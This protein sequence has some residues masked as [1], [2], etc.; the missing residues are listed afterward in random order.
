[1]PHVVLLGDSIFDNRAYVG[2]NPDVRQQTE[3][4]LFFAN[5]KVTLLAR[6]GAVIADVAQQFKLLPKDATHLVISAG[7]ND[8]LREAGVLDA[9]AS[10]VS[11]AL[12]KLAAVSDSVSR[13]YDTMLGEVS[14][15][16]L[17]TAVCTIYE[18]RFPEKMRRY[19]AAIALALIND[20]I[21]RHAFSRGL[22]LIDLRLV[23]NEDADFANAIEPSAHGGEKIGKAISK[24]TIGAT[25]GS[26][27]FLHR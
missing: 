8:A 25:G 2:V 19:L 3:Q 21:L 23:C 13:K 16:G 9:R 11:D 15:A 20:K 5:A 26:S 7:G 1:M 4:A 14:R 18:P 6:D 24:Y 22:K 12:Q 17:P 10:S 27:V